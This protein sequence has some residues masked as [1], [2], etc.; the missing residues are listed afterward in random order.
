MSNNLKTSFLQDDGLDETLQLATALCTMPIGLISLIDENQQHY[1]SHIGLSLTDAFRLHSF[2]SNGIKDPGEI[3]IIEDAREDVRLSTNALV[4]DEPNIVFYAGIPLLDKKGLALGY[5]CLI[6]TKPRKISSIE[7]NSIKIL[8]KQVIQLFSQRQLNSELQSEKENFTNCISFISPYF[9]LLNKENQIIAIGKNYQKSKSEISPGKYFGEFFYWESSFNANKLLD[10]SDKYDRLL[11]FVSQDNKS[12]FKCTVK[13]KTP[14][15]YFIFASPVINTLYPIS[16]YHINITNFPKHDYIAE[17]LFLQQSATKGLEDAQKLNQLI[18]DKNK[19]LEEARNTLIKVNSTLEERIN[20]GVQ[21]IKRLALF[22]EQNPNPVIEISVDSFDILYLNPYAKELFLVDEQVIQRDELIQA[23]QIDTNNPKMANTEPIDIEINGKIFERNLFFNEQFNSL[24]LYLH[25]ITQ[26]RQKEQEER[27]KIDSFIKKQNSLN[28]IRKLDKS[29]TLE[30]K[31]RSISRIVAETIGCDRCSIWLSNTD[32]SLITTNHVYLLKENQFLE[33]MEIKQSVAPAYFKA[34]GLKKII[35]ATNAFQNEATYE[36]TESYLKPLNISSMLDIP[37]LQTNQSIGVLCCE[38]FQKQP[39]FDSD[40]VAFCSSVADII[41]LAC[42][43]NDLKNSQKELEIKNDLL[44]ENMEKIIN[45]QSE[46][47]EREKLATLGMLIAGIAHEINSPLGAI[48]ASNEYLHK[49]FSESLLSAIKD[50]SPEIIQAGLNLF[51]LRQ[52][53]LIATTTRDIRRIQKETILQIKNQFPSI[54]NINFYASVLVD[55]GLQNKTDQLSRFLY[56]PQAR[57]LFGFAQYLS[58]TLKA[59]D[60]IGLAVNRAGAVVK[61]LNTFSHGNIDKELSSFKLN[62]SL[63]SVI[64]LLWNK[65][66]YNAYVE[67]NIPKDILVTGSAD[68]L[69][70]VWTN[71]INNALQASDNKCRIWIDYH[72][73]N[74]WQIVS[75]SNNGPMISPEIVDRIFDAF[76]STKKRG[77]GTGLGLNIVK[78]I[79]EKHQGQITCTS[80]EQTTCFVIKLPKTNTYTLHSAN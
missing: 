52:G 72:E 74:T 79:I 59:V 39:S 57:E 10:E 69:A 63:N 16:H 38:F 23:L 7:L 56:H 13:K 19:K 46:I 49:N 31:F 32:L 22:P 62:E 33:G 41:V 25:D 24:R 27:T 29:L 14:D 42:E 34:L 65:I 71:V 48:K 51:S 45:M 6:D 67:N 77:E 15:T 44:R 21:K 9:I 5:L 54:D 20:E 17:Y 66:K 55:L 61:A 53:N 2:Y 30:Q 68:E 28:T 8:S 40:V 35:Y 26:K 1:Q 58:H 70:Q 11:F 73:D 18:L 47:V 43:T 4:T 50:I 76:F 60:T 78:K 80:N 3:T 36:F 12:K 75:I 37:L 64:T